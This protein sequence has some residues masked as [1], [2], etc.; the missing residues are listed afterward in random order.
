MAKLKRYGEEKLLF[1]WMGV[2]N[3]VFVALIGPLSMVFRQRTLISVLH[4]STLF[5]S[6]L[7]E[8]GEVQVCARLSR[9]DRPRG[10]SEK[11]LCA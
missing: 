2:S 9:A 3:M 5:F 1:V 6:P 4:V 11:H 7:T 10:S 8:S